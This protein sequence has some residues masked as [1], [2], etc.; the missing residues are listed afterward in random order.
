MKK[1]ILLLV[2]ACAVSCPW[3]L[4]AQGKR[5][6]DRAWYA[7]RGGFFAGVNESFHQGDV[8]LLPSPDN[9]AFADG[10]GTNFVFGLH[11]EKAFTRYIALGLNIM[12]DQM[13][14]SV[15]G[16]FTEPYRIADDQGTLYDVTRDQ[17]TDYT[18]QYLSFGVYTKLYPMAGPGFYV[19]AGFSLSTRVKDDY[20]FTATIVEPE[21]AKGSVS[22]P[23]SGSIPE[24]NNLRYAVNVNLGYDFAF[25][26]GFITPQLAYEFGLNPVSDA[27][28]AETWKVDNLRFI[29][30]LT[31]P[32]P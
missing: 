26:Y 27:K 28:Y 16:T 31:F 3:Q 24:V 30:A 22:P 25:R 12:F 1:C 4:S 20:S 18:L 15:E 5:V 14:G 21:W 11:G 29:L 8:P 10:M 13:S 17:S 6:S 2:I 9:T 19:G 32:V 7:V 23:E